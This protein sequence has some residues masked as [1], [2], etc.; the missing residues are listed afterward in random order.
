MEAIDELVP[1]TAEDLKILEAKKT[2]N[3]YGCGVVMII[4]FVVMAFLALFYFSSSYLWLFILAGVSVLFLIAG[5]LAFWM[6]P[7]EDEKVVLDIQEGKKRRIVAPIESK[8]IVEA[9]P[10]RSAFPRSQST[11][12]IFARQI[13]KSYAPLDLKYSMKVQGFKFALSEGQYL[14][15]F[16]KGDF[17]EF[18]V[19][20][21]SKI[22]LS[23]AE[24]VP[25]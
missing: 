13:A 17:V 24:E 1:L 3:Y 8:D 11:G 19:A 18:F 9:P 10:K 12:A 20:P 2:S 6:G 21:H 14:S 16:R 22:I 15:G 7:I 5:L 4:V 25:E 23:S